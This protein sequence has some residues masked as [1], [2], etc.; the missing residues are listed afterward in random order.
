MSKKNVIFILGEGEEQNKIR[1]KLFW[2]VTY[3]AIKGQLVKV[4]HKG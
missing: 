1:L 3:L 4:L 2:N